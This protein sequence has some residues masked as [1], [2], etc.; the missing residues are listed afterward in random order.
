VQVE[1]LGERRRHDRGHDRPPEGGGRGANQ[2][3]LQRLKAILEA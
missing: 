1:E 3:D 2:K